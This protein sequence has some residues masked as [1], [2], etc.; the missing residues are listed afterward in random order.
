MSAL[1]ISASVAVLALFLLLRGLRLAPTRPLPPGPRG[2]PFVG[3]LFQ[4]PS[5]LMWFQMVEWSKEYGPMFSY[6][7]LGQT[8][9]VL[10]RVKE[11][12]DLLDRMSAKTS[13]R[14]RMIKLSEHMC[15]RM[16][17]A[18]SSIAWRSLFGHETIPLLGFDPTKP[19]EEFSAEIFR[20]VV[21]G[22]S[23]VDVFR[24]L[25]PIILRF[26]YFRRYSDRCYQTITAF[27]LKAYSDPQVD[28]VPS[29][30]SK[31]KGNKERFGMK[32]DIDC[33]WV[34]GTLFI[35][36]QDTTAT[37]LRW[38]FVAMLLYPETA[39]A[40]RAQ[41]AS[42]V[43]DRPPSFSDSERLPQI[44]ALVKELLRWRPAAAG[45]IPHMAN[46]DIIYKNYLIPKGAIISPVAWSICR[47]PSLYPNGDTFDPSRFLDE[48]GNIKRPAQHSHDDYLAFG[49]G[50][51][52]CVG[53]NL[54]INTLWITIATLLWAF[55]F[56][57]SVDEHGQ[58]VAPDPMAFWDNG[59][60]VWPAKFGA[61]LVPRVED[62]REKLKASMGK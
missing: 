6:T 30:S 33:S 58:E 60:T 4:L 21:P 55:D 57:L 28:T 48:M 56:Q 42:V 1:Y 32:D 26:K 18:S 12:T 25:N 40:A 46:E 16:E 37:S 17:F 19:I 22:G 59:A 11:A 10:T 9:I 2:L 29:L 62:L 51:R 54:A 35:A 8:V 44:D 5:K 38:F 53:K 14:P 41:L 23:I 7:I 13:D 39:L 24:F 50:R 47:D 3:N 61:R 49:H 31:L 20:C 52:I 34:G 36:A 15:R 43:G 27:F 45:G